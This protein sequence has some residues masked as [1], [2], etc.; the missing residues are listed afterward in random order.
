LETGPNA[1][2]LRY[3]TPATP[4]GILLRRSAATLRPVTLPRC[5]LPQVV[6]RI[7]LTAPFFEGNGLP[8]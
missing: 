1:T 4:A 2:F 3:G 7:I 6:G 5:Y 8:S